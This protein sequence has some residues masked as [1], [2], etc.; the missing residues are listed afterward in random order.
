[1]RTIPEFLRNHFADGDIQVGETQDGIVPVH[2]QFSDGNVVAYQMVV[3]QD[4][5]GK[6]KIVDEVPRDR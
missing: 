3:E 6:W 2:V 4:L 1:M 5:T